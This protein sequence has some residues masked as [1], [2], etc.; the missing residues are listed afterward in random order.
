MAYKYKDYARVCNVVADKKKNCRFLVEYE[1]ENGDENKKALI[2]M[3]NPSKADDQISDQTI[4]NVLE[5][6]HEFQYSKVFVMN[7]IPEYA[8]NP[9]D[10]SDNVS[11]DI[12]NRND[13]LIQDI[14]NQVSKVF[15]A[16]GGSNGI[17]EV[18]YN[19]RILSVKK[20]LTD[21]KLYCYDI[22]AVNK[23]PIHPSYSHWKKGKE[24]KDFVEYQ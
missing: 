9:N 7:L 8:T 14:S 16:W 12:L 10:I 18:F 21:K 4:N 17:N 2:I 5:Y 3:K 19:S 24:E 6:M 20:C 1:L 15:V 11:M 22:N 13:K 23:Q